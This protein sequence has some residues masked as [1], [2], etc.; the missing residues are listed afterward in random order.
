MEEWKSIEDYDNYEISNLGN[1][2]NKTTNKLLTP[3]LHN[4][5][6]YKIDL[7]KNGKKKKYYIHRLIAK[8]FIP[9]PYNLAEIDHI[10]RNKSNNS[11]NNLR[12]ITHTN[13]AYNINKKKNSNSKYRNVYYE[14]RRNHWICQMKINGKQ[15]YIGSF[16]TEEEGAIAFNEAIKKYNLEDFIEPIDL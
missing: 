1:V 6:Y 4:A 15:T 11:I 14:K 12:W 10:D 7:C 5:G 9:N 2:K 16:D 13:N 3:Y 8:A